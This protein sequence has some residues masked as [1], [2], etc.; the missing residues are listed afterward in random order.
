MHHVALL[1]QLGKLV[2]NW[3]LH[4]QALFSYLL[5][6]AIDDQGFQFVTDPVESSVAAQH[7]SPVKRRDIITIRIS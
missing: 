7:P 2:L 5:K 6:E 4:K 3:M 1:V